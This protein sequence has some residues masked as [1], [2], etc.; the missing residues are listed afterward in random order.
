MNIKMLC[1][2]ALTSG[3]LAAALLT[4]CAAEPKLTIENVSL[5]ENTLT[6]TV[7]SD[8]PLS[9]ALI[10]AIYDDTGVLRSVSVE[11]NQTEQKEWII[12]AAAEFEKG[13]SKIFFWNSLDEMTPWVS[14]A[15]S[16]WTKN[17][18]FDAY[19]ED[20]KISDVISDKC[21]D[22]YGRLIFPVNSG[23]YSGDTLK[24]LRLTWYNYID[25]NKTV[26]IANY[27]KK[28]AA[29]GETIFYD[30]YTEAEKAENPEKR[31][32]GLFFFR[33]NPGEKFA[34]CN[35]GGGFAYVGAMHDS[36]P[37]ALELSKKGYNAFALIYRLGWET[38]YEDLGRAISF[39]IDNA[40][41]L[42]VDTDGYSLWGGSAGARMAATLGN[43]NYLKQYSE[44]ID[45]P[46]TA[47]VIMQYTGYTDASANDAP[48]YACVGTN[49]GIASWRTMQNRLNTLTNSYGI[50][51]EFHA[52]DGLP[53]GFGLGTG[54]IAE[55]W[56]DD[57]VAFWEKH[58]N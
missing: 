3:I 55:G 30:I 27:L 43:A 34:V 51:T 11:E 8:I 10:C 31:N 17:N 16:E 6:Y 35:A 4:A 37:H 5:M 38:A 1:A 22:D 20:T 46:Q 47:A 57:A 41:E 18:H 39:I 28:H 15:S 23:Y 7:S 40:D 26:E 19:T 33:G 44:R 53:H 13:M 48:T 32:T 54:T 2:C 56:V 14:S 9:G 52:Y 50:E 45:I 24:N 12:E 25:P 49:D 21:F 36:F 58:I 29:G 42:G